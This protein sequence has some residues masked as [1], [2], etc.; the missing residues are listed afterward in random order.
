[1]GAVQNMQAAADMQ[2]AMVLERL[3]AEQ[4]ETNRLLRQLA[5]EPQPPFEASDQG[6]AARRLRRQASPRR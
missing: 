4:Q 5:G 3:V 1:M 6:R 2:T